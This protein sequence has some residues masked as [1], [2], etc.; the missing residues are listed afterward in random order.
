MNSARGGQKPEIPEAV[1]AMFDGM[2]KKDPN[3]FGMLKQFVLDPTCLSLSV[4]EFHE[5][6]KRKEKGGTWY[7]VTE[8]ELDIH[9]KSHLG[10]TGKQMVKDTIAKCTNAERRQHKR[11]KGKHWAQYHCQLEDYTREA[12]EERSGLRV[13]TE[14]ETETPAQASSLLKLMETSNIRVPTDK[15]E[16]AKAKAKGK[17]AM[18]LE[19]ATSSQSSTPT[20][21]VAPSPPRSTGRRTDYEANQ[22]PE[23]IAR[24]SKE[25]RCF[26]KEHQCVA[27]NWWRQSGRLHRRGH[28]STHPETRGRETQAGRNGDRGDHAGGPGNRAAH[29]REGSNLEGFKNRRR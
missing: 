1:V 21:V 2:T 29:V 11:H 24:S 8:W 10:D 28:G 25:V 17:L 9:F 27:G 3:R 13:A 19:S 16:K 6:M 12:D 26:T 14:A 4:T 18:D 5:K 20:E 15:K 22:P 23:R 7:W